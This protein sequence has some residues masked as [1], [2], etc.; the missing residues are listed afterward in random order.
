MRLSLENNLLS[1]DNYKQIMNLSSDL[2]QLEEIMIQG[3]NMNVL[4]LDK[5]RIVLEG[6]FKGIQLGDN[7]HDIQN[8]N[9]QK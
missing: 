9:G 6:T 1:V 7:K 4:Y 3:C 8:N 2:I 5:Y